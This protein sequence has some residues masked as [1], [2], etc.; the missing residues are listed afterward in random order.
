MKSKNIYRA[1]F[2]LIIVSVAVW[3]LAIKGVLHKCPEHSPKLI[4]VKDL[5]TG[6]VGM[7]YDIGPDGINGKMADCDTYRAWKQWEADQKEVEQ[8]VLFNDYAARYM[9]PSGAPKEK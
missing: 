4:T 8:A 2:L 1:W 5:Q 3:M 7:D 6:L 9:T